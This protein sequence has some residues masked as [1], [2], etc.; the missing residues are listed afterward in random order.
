L[1]V[2]TPEIH[3]DFV[4]ASYA[5]ESG[6]LGVILYF[7]LMGIFFLLGFREAWRKQSCFSRILAI[8]LVMSIAVQ[9]LINIAVVAN[10]IPTTGIPLPFISSGG[11]SLLMTLVSAGLIVN[12]SKQ[13]YIKGKNSVHGVHSASGHAAEDGV[14]Y[15]G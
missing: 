13:N 14:Y 5:E 1:K 12:A 6:F 10:I 11:S 8:A 9:T 15:V 7:V 2:R 4:F 3:G